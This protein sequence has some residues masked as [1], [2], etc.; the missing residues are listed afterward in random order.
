MAIQRGVHPSAEVLRAIG[1]GKLEENT[2]AVVRDH[3]DHYEDCRKEVAAVSGDGFL[4]RLRRAHGRSYTP[5]P[6][7]PPAE[8]TRIPQ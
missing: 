4:H 7:K 2:F 6:S 8:N 5:V 3:F 1:L